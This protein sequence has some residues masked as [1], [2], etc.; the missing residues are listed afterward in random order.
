MQGTHD[1]LS[2]ERHIKDA[3]TRI[4][5][6]TIKREWPQQWPSMIDELDAIYKQGVSKFLSI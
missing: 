5:V 2:E 3:V 1:I 6:E 4:V